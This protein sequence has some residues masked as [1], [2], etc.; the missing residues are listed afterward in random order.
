MGGSHIEVW[1]GG[2]VE[3]R[4]VVRLAVAESDGRLRCSSGD[5]HAPVYARSAVKPLQALPLLEDGVAARL[6]LTA[7]ELALACGSHSGEARH[8]EIARSML[9]KAGATESDL[10]CGPHSPF[11]S[12]TSREMRRQGLEPGRVHNNCSGKHAGMIALAVGHGWDPH[13]YHEPGHLVQQRMLREMARWCEHPAEAF[14]TATDGCGVVTFAAP[15]ERLALGFARFAA[16]ARDG[17]PGPRGI[18]DAMTSHPEL[19]G[20]TGRLCTAIMRA[21]GGRVFVKVGAEGVYCAGAPEAGLGIAMKVEDGAGRAAEC[22]IVALLGQLGLIREDEAGH[23]AS[24][25][26]PVVRNTR[27]ERV[28]RITPALRLEMADA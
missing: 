4:H 1:R 6:G 18:A 11:H 23:L 14:V 24:F 8:V 22:A 13:G 12:G 3:S 17:S 27:G 15:L 16:A 26:E 28:G 2:L 20:G 21:T 25:A 7:E 5:V 9:A 10:A 19:V